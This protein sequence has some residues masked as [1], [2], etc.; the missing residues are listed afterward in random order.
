MGDWST[1]TPFEVLS[2]AAVVVAGTLAG[3]VQHLR[4]LCR[5]SSVIRVDLPEPET[6]VMHTSL[7]SAVNVD[8]LQVVLARPDLTDRRCRGAEG[9]ASVF[10]V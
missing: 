8:V 6:P 10:R 1:L 3:P 9:W 5:G 4:R 7:P 2:P